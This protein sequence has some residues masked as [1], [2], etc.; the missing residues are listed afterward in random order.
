MHQAIVG[1]GFSAAHRHGP[2]ITSLNGL[3]ML[4]DPPEIQTQGTLIESLETNFLSQ[5][6][7]GWFAENTQNG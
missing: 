6:S 7:W 3:A 4:L 2:Q 1:F 5:I